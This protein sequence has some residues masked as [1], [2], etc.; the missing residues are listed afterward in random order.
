MYVG[1]I[2]LTRDCSLGLKG[3][4]VLV[5]E[6]EWNYTKFLVSMKNIFYTIGSKTYYIEGGEFHLLDVYELRK[7]CKKFWC[8]I[9]GG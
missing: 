9:Y 1:S 3:Q 8:D 5:T 4:T 2:Y 6:D 7:E